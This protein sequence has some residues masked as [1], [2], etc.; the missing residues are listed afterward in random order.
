MKGNSINIL[1][2]IGYI[3]FFPSSVMLYS[4][5]NFSTIILTGNVS[6]IISFPI[7]FLPVLLPI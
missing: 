6:H 5:K 3:F 1:L 2:V 7:L 4:E